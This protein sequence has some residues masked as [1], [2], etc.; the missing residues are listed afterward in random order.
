MKKINDKEAVDKQLPEICL[1]YGTSL[2]ECI[3]QGQQK[4]ANFNQD[5]KYYVLQWTIHFPNNI[6][7]PLNAINFYGNKR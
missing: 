1:A 6:R 2:E 3:S 7:E 4:C 5:T